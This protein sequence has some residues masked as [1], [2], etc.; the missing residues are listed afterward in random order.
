MRLRT[1]EASRSPVMAAGRRNAA[2]VLGWERVEWFE[3]F[4]QMKSE[5][6]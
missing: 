3:S 5:S 2:D 4:A 6:N 1:P